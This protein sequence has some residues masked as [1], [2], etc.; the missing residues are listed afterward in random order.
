MLHK[1]QEKRVFKLGLEIKF[2][3][4]YL[5][6]HFGI[7]RVWGCE[8]EKLIAYRVMLWKICFVIGKFDKSK[9][10]NMFPII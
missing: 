1:S 6:R 7:I 5:P 10:T 4:S 8:Q 2:L 9:P 3:K